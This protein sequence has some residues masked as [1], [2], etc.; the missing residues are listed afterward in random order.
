MKIFTQQFQQMA[1]MLNELGSQ[2][3]SEAMGPITSTLQATLDHLSAPSE[4]IR[5]EPGKAIGIRKV[6]KP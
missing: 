2:K 3:L 1:E 6:V 4:V 5:D